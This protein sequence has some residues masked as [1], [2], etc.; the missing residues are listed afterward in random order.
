MSAAA[1]CAVH[2]LPV[3]VLCTCCCW[4]VPAHHKRCIAHVNPLANK[5]CINVA[6]MAAQQPMCWTP[7]QL[8]EAC[9]VWR[10]LTCEVRDACVLQGD[11]TS[12]Q[13]HCVG[14]ASQ[15]PLAASLGLEKASASLCASS[16]TCNTTSTRLLSCQWSPACILQGG[17]PQQ[18]LVQSIL[19]ILHAGPSDGSKT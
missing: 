2:M 1:N 8:L 4:P 5:L 11:A 19:G 12:D 17:M 14:R 10:V 7:Q 16:R 6:D 18:Q 13:A 15:L 3:N 9:A